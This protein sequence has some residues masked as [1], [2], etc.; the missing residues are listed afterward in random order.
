MDGQSDESTSSYYTL[1][2]MTCHI[3]PGVQAREY[4]VRPAGRVLGWMDLLIWMII[5][6]CVRVMKK[7]NGRDV[8][9]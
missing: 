3:L 9:T 2:S 6:H 4:V 1:E 5:L 8:S 7:E